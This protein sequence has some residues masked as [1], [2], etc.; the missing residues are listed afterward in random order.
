VHRNAT[1]TIEQL[2][3]SRRTTKEFR[4]DPVPQEL[5][6]EI[7]ELAQW[8]PNHRL[9]H[10]WRFRVLGKHAVVALEQAAGEGAAK[11]RRAPTLVAVSAEL[12]GN[13]VHDAEDVA[14]TAC[15]MYTALLAAHARGL[16]TYWRTPGVLR[17]DAG[18]AACGIGEGEQAIG[19]LHLGWSDASPELPQ[20]EPIEKTLEF[21]D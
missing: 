16:A 6:R 10:P 15:A 1:D 14:A 5:L 9:N 11:L 8:A 20:R 18:R 21:L 12:S 17:T 2:V 13:S 4:A 3:R 19:L 7:F